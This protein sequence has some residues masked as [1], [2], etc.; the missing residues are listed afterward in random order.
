MKSAKELIEGLKEKD[1]IR[2][3]AYVKQGAFLK[4]CAGVEINLKNF[5]YYV[6]NHILG[7]RY[8]APEPFS[9]IEFPKWTDK[10]GNIYDKIFSDS[11]ITINIFDFDKVDFKCDN[12]RRVELEI[13][14][15]YFWPESQKPKPRQF[16]LNKESNTVT[17]FDV[18]EKEVKSKIK[19][20]PSKEYVNYGIDYYEP[21]YKE[22]K[23]NYYNTK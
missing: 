5:I 2:Y 18:V 14:S 13:F 4:T 20:H 8:E 17:F 16:S 6:K 23:R 11:C 22:Y 19:E 10:S 1:I 12:C 15:N 21:L 3:L 7:S 9:K